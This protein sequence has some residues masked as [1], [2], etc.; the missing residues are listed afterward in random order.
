MPE[1]PEVETIARQLAPLIEG[2][3]VRSVRVLDPLIDARPTTALVGRRVEQVRR[4]GKQVVL[5]LAGL[6][7]AIHLRMTG[8]LIWRE[9]S[10][11]QGRGLIARD[12]LR[13]WLG[14]TGGRLAFHD[15]RR[16]GTLRVVD[17]L[18]AIQPPGA[19]PLATSFTL[20]V[21]ADLL[22]G[23]SQPIKVWLLRQD[24][25][26]GLGNIYASEIL[27]EGGI[28]PRKPAG[29]LRPDRVARLH[30]VMRQVLT[31]AIKSC[32]TTFS[33]FQDAHGLTGS[34]QG[35]LC[36]YGREGE[37][38]P[39]CGAQVRRL[40]QQQRSTFYCGRCQR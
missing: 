7:V 35:C 39:R 15:T 12:H 20:S 30:R 28:D 34:Y 29:S 25:I 5:D 3:R 31:R 11:G 18:D 14:L 1:L 4:L 22:Q 36:V 17:S 33:D 9:T 10:P 16:F 13:A 24:R 26:T 6:W 2:R 23:S 32:G 37:S 40:V 21:L 27:F 8:R 19:D 38:C